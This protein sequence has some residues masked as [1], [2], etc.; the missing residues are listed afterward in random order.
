MCISVQDQFQLGG[1]AEDCCPKIFC[2]ARIFKMNQP[3]SHVFNKIPLIVYFTQYQNDIEMGT[4]K[5][6]TDNTLSLKV[7]SFSSQIPGYEKIKISAREMEMSP[8]KIDDVR[9][10]GRLQ[11]PPARTPMCTCV[12]FGEK[13]KWDNLWCKNLDTAEHFALLVNPVFLNKIF[14]S[15]KRKPCTWIKTIKT[16][17]AFPEM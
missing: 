12:K 9:I 4:N 14:L 2:I 3:L 15:K 10:W 11:S 1:R 6:S 13:C 5:I 16:N 8:E 7:L 17:I